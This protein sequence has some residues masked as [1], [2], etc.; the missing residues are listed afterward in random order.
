MAGG[1]RTLRALT[2]DAPLTAD[3]GAVRLQVTVG[4]EDADGTCAVRVFSR[5]EDAPAD[6]PWTR[7][8][9]GTLV[10]AGDAERVPARDGDVS[11]EVEAEGASGWGVHPALLDDALAA[12]R[13]AWCPAP[14]VASPCTPW[15]PPGCGY[16]CRRWGRTRSP[17]TPPTS[18][19]RP[20]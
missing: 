4:V 2:E 15:A 6:Q 20:S 16:A 18:P 10:T 7:H 17:C 8:A 1:G 9:T 19:G 5:P 12:V 3:A 14:G 11:V 13:P